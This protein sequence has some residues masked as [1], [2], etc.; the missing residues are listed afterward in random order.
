MLLF[1]VCSFALP[2][3][4][5]ASIPF[6][7]PIIPQ[8][9]DQAVCA[10]SWGML[11]TVINN[12]IE[13]LITLVIVF[14]APLMV[15]YSGFLFVV[16]PVNASGKEEAK[17][18][19]TNTVV[20]IVIA[21][22]GWMIV[23]AL[24]AVL[25]NPKAVGST[26]SDIIGSK[27]LPVCIPLKASLNPA[28]T[29]GLS[30]VQ[31]SAAER[32][33]RDSLQQSGVMIN[34]GPCSPDSSGS[35]CTNVAGMQQ[36]TVDQIIN[37]KNSCGGCPV[38]VTG[39]TEPGHASGQYS[40]ENGYK[41]DIDSTNSTLN[42]FLQKLPLTGQRGGDSGGPIRSDSCQNQ[43]VQESNHWDITIF[44]TCSI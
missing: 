7:G 12:I 25:Y 4:A 32:A 44:Q 30:V 22:A 29:E 20:G 39:G 21:L 8:S 38:I 37:I 24:M 2:L 11:L 9:G 43:Y 5:H 19:L 34:N 3:A 1:T 33:I 23:A 15:A 36:A 31:G 41:V 42:A 13:L 14:V 18:I 16:N 28:K 10:A 26:W 35:G 6:F 27:G 17:K 40:H